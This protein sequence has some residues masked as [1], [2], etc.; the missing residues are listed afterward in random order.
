VAGTEENKF[1][2][3]SWGSKAVLL[4]TESLKQEIR[5]EAEAMA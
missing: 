2:V 5:S 3:M 4:E 1:W